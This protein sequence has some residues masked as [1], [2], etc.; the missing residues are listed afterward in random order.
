MQVSQEQQEK[1][2]NYIALLTKYHKALDLMSSKGLK[3]IDA[4]FE[5]AYIFSEIIKDI[6]IDL[7]GTT[8][9][10]IGSGAGLPAVPLAIF[11]P[12]LQFM[13]VERRQR[14]TSF[15]TIVKSQLKLDN[16]QV[17]N[18][19]VQDVQREDLQGSN[20]ELSK[21]KLVTALW[22][23]DFGLLL[24][25]TEHLFDQHC[26]F[27]SKKATDWTIE[28]ESLSEEIDYKV[29]EKVLPSHGKLVTLEIEK[30]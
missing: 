12:E 10:D 27:I 29:S 8:T 4:R 28:R 25:I 26:I 22:V 15:L 3:D 18:S 23:G 19:D 20:D 14:R 24:D 16:I 17:V 1:L 5:E 30:K 2:N 7:S 11:L 9:L 6:D 21:V 13:L